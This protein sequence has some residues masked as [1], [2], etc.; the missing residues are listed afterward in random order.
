MKNTSRDYPDY[1]IVLFV[2]V[3]FV[4]VCFLIYMLFF[5]SAFSKR[6]ER[7][8][9]AISLSGLQQVRYS[10]DENNNRYEVTIDSITYVYSETRLLSDI[11]VGKAKAY[12]CGDGIHYHFFWMIDTTQTQI[13]RSINVDL[14]GENS[15]D[16]EVEVWVVK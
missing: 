1:R 14:Q 16:Y 8:S 9:P 12:E 10:F 2:L 13:I 11:R 4:L 6:K 5:V 15:R 7:E 3:A